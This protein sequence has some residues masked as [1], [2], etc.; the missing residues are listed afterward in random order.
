[1]KRKG[2]KALGLILA[3]EMIFPLSEVVFASSIEKEGGEKLEK[4]IDART[5]NDV[6]D[7]VEEVL[8][9]AK[10]L[11]QEQIAISDNKKVLKTVECQKQKNSEKSYADYYGGSYINENGNLV[12]QLCDAT[13]VKQQKLR[14]V[15]S[16][17]VIFEEVENSYKS[18]DEKIEKSSTI[19]IEL[20]KQNAAGE[21]SGELKELVDCIV[22]MGTKVE[23][24]RNVVYMTDISEKMQTA[25][26]KYFGDDSV[27]FEKSVPIKSSATLMPQGSGIVIRADTGASLGPRMKYLRNNGNYVKGFMTAGHATVA[28]GDNVSFEKAPGKYISVGC[29]IKRQCRGSVDAAFVMLDQTSYEASRYAKYINSSGATGESYKMCAE[30]TYADIPAIG[31]TVY[32]SGVT[33]YLTSSQVDSVNYTAHYE[34]GDVLTKMI[35]TKTCMSAPGDSGANVFTKEHGSVYESV[36][37]ISGAAEGEC[38]VISCM[39]V[40]DEVWKN[41]EGY[42]LYQY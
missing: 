23:K 3:L 4:I 8:L 27:I 36:G 2:I 12:I 17:A 1:M 5:E 19:L 15:T 16:D 38:S 25:Y 24:N 37:L 13:N 32:K 10:R 6:T 20:E 29:V 41:N 14:K 28:Y 22:G 26:F 42:P 35:K 39:D 21:L 30:C 7:T 9:D 40:I 31:Q 34:D 33:T 11:E 18:L